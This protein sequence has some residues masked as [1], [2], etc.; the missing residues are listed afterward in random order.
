MSLVLGPTSPNDPQRQR[1]LEPPAEG[2]P[3]ARIGARWVQFTAK[4]RPNQ[5][6]PWSAGAVH[7]SSSANSCAMTYSDRTPAPLVVGTFVAS[8]PMFLGDG[9]TRFTRATTTH[10]T[11]PASDSVGASRRV[12][13]PLRPSARLGRRCYDARQKHR[14]SGRRSRSVGGSRGGIIWQRPS[15]RRSVS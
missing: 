4:T 8:P 3:L 5:S 6:T 13:L 9:V 14:V 10:P 11:A 15:G 7:A 2:P 12:P 1:S